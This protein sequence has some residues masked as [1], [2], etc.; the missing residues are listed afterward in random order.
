MKAVTMRR[1]FRSLSVFVRLCSKWS[2]RSFVASNAPSEASLTQAFG[3]KD[4]LLT[5]MAP[6][7]TLYDLVKCSL[8]L[9]DI[10]W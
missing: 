1:F 10:R 3:L 4:T 6:P 8:T 2:H 7:P 5:I 9:H